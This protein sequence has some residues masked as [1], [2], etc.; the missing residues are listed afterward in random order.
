[1]CLA[2]VGQVLA[3]DAAGATA[4][5]AAGGRRLAVSLAPIVL[6]GG[7]VA[8]GEWLMIHTGLAVTVLDE[9]EAREIARLAALLAP[10]PDPAGSA[11]PA[12]PGGTET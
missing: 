9:D 8:I 11:G 12:R 4:T 2:V 10:P 3:V 1:M 7:R 6:D 5:V